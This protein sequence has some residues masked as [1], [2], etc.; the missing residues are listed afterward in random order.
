MVESES[1]GHYG[2]GCSREEAMVVAGHGDI[3]AMEG[4][5]SE[6]MWNVRSLGEL[7]LRAF[8]ASVEYRRPGIVA[9]PV[10][11]KSFV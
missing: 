10:G 6:A 5:I 4:S 7:M 2:L 11:F 9:L 1:D 8:P 3:Q